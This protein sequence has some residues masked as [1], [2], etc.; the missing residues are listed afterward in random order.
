MA[1]IKQIRFVFKG[2]KCVTR[3]SLVTVFSPVCGTV[4]MERIFGGH[5]YV[6]YALRKFEWAQNF[7]YINMCIVVCF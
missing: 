1:Y 4:L 2:L 6:F 7:F 3:S 5:F